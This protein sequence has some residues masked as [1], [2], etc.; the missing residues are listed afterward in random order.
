[1]K[2]LKTNRSFGKALF[3]TFGVAMSTAVHAQQNTMYLSS[4]EG[5]KI[6]LF[7]NRINATNMYGFGVRDYTLY[8]KSYGNYAWVMN[9]NISASDD[10]F[11]IFNKSHMHLKKDANGPTLTIRESS[12]FNN[13]NSGEL[14]LL[15][16]SGNITS[17]TLYGGYISYD[18]SANKMYLGSYNGS[19]KNKAITIVR[20][21]GCVGIGTTSPSS[22]YKLS[23]NGKIRAKEIVVETGWADYVFEQ[24]YNLRSLNEVESFI[25]KNGHLPDVPSAKDVEKNGVTVGEM[26]AT[27]LRKIEELTLYMIEMKKENE[28]L[29]AEI[30]AM[31]K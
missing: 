12:N 26:E 29:K 28:A 30:D 25:A 24:D 18:G 14:R 22:S 2:T 8:N 17:G 9:T 3:L 16:R 4:V 1:M 31:K 11:D 13:A 23:V 21:N 7:G 15:E 27:L 20:S 5:D 10:Q 6:S 19:T